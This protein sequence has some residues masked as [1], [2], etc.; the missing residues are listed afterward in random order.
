MDRNKEK[1]SGE[2]KRRLYL[3]AFGIAVF[4]EIIRFVYSIGEYQPTLIG[5]A[6]IIAAILYYGYS[7]I[8]DR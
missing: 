2:D 7:W 4:I 8:T 6:I 5:L 3:I 1:P